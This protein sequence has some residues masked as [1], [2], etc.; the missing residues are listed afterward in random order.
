MKNAH[1]RLG[2]LEYHRSSAK[3]DTK[4]AVP[5][6]CYI[7]EDRQV[8][9]ISVY[10]GDAEIGAISAAIYERHTFTVLFP[11]GGSKVVELGPDA[12]CYRGHIQ[13]AGHKRGLR[14][15]V[16][17]SAALHANGTAG[18]TYIFHLRPETYDLAWATLVSQLGLPADPRWG[19]PVLEALRAAKKMSRL[20]AIGCNP[21]SIQATRED[22]L[23]HIAKGLREGRLSFPEQ[24]GPVVW[25][26]YSLSQ[27]LRSN[28]VEST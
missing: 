28:G 22:L 14:H 21:V 10:G 11:E 17:L 5:L 15:L 7:G 1:L 12:V 26:A 20:E 9:L 23:Q 3:M 8:H 6:D 4:F 24:N 2:R 18:R 25:P 16:A 19:R 27:L 13:L